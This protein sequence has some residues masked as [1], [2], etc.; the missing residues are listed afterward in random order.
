[1]SPQTTIRAGLGGL[2][3]LALGFGWYGIRSCRRAQADLAELTQKLTHLDAN[4]RQKEA[5]TVARQQEVSALRAKLEGAPFPASAN[6]RPGKADPATLLAADAR[7]RNLYLK[8]FRANLILRFGPMY[9][10]LGLSQAQIDKFEDLTTDHEG[11]RMEI[12]AAALAQGLAPADPSVVTLQARSDD[13]YRAALTAALG[14]DLS[15]Q[16]DQID[17]TQPAQTLVANIAGMVPG[18]SAPLTQAQGSQLIQILADAS[19]SYQAG[20]KPDPHTI[21]WDEA[22]VRATA[23]LSGPQLQA[24]NAEAQFYRLGAEAAQ[25]YAQR[26]PSTK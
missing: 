14:A 17:R 7:L 21:N 19:P 16:L 12:R 4:V 23:I 3:L 9:Q 24:F 18:A 20:G 25:F 11:E 5:R 22:S 10:N 2:L 1:M 6:H 26:Q 15:P 8:S 13:Q